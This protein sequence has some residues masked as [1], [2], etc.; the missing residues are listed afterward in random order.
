MLNERPH[1]VWWFHPNLSRSRGTANC[2]KQATER[3]ILTRG[4]GSRE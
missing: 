1:E 3:R 4:W 2:V